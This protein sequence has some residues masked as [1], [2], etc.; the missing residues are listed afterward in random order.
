[1]IKYNDAINVI[2]QTIGEQTL[3]TGDSIDNIYEAEQADMII[4][5]VKLEILSE[6]WSFNTDTDWELIPDSEGY[7][8]L[9][10]YMLRVD[11]AATASNYIRK[12]SKLYD[13]TN[14][15]FI[16]TNSVNCDIVWELD[17]DDIPLIAQRYITLKAA[18]IM[19]QR[20]VGDSKVVEA[21]LMDERD[22][23][24]R[25]RMYEDDIEDVNIFDDTTVSRLLTRTS[26]PTGIRG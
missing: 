3:Q 20:F 25:L 6:G 15:T 11:A 14:K 17:F 2:L 21:L 8:V 23:L 18:R 9:P 10:D 4:E 22:A 26:N 1:M 13:R 7:I 12:D 16:F 24:L 19:Y 5:Q